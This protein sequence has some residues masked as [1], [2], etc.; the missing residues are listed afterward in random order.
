M[1]NLLFLILFA[2]IFSCTNNQDIYTLHPGGPAYEL[3]E[4]L[5]EKLP[6]LDP[7]KNKILVSSRDFQIGTHE[8]IHEFTNIY[9]VN[10][11]SLKNLGKEQLKMGVNRLAYN[12]A[13]E[14]LFLEE[15]A[16]EGIEIEKAALDSALNLHFAR[17]GGRIAFLKKLD[18]LDIQFDYI[19]KDIH[20]ALLIERL[21]D[22]I[23]YDEVIPPEDKELRALYRGS[24]PELVSFRHLVLGARD[25]SGSQIQRKAAEIESIWKRAQSGDSFEE[26][27]RRYSEDE[28]SRLNGGL[29]QELERGMME[30]TIESVAFS[31]PE[32]TV[33]DVFRTVDGFNIIKV[34][35]R[36]EL[37][38][39]QFKKRN[40]ETIYQKKKNQAYRV[41]INDLKVKA[42]FL[43]FGL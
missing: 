24:D 1:R 34:E 19:K 5:S 9:G 30:A 31:T 17:A 33:S 23:V 40:F 15:A 18:Q 20:D 14:K 43:F 41:Y 11:K 16:G 32:G 28:S 38:Y 13:M 42:E 21:I 25:Q 35:F 37:D 39:E 22:E 36:T 6:Q 3:A 4:D 29:Y 26:L 10:A 7:E 27:V 12:L 2:G 8:V